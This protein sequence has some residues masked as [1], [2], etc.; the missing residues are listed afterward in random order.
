M[1]IACVS[2]AIPYYLRFKIRH[3]S[4]YTGQCNCLR[5]PVH[6]L[7]LGSVNAYTGQCKTENRRSRAD[8][9]PERCWLSGRMYL[10]VMG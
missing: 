7:T 6:V 1:S 8:K 2:D 9:V 4:S 10:N 3:L 5:S